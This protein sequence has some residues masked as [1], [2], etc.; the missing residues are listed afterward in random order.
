MGLGTGIL[1]LGFGIIFNSPSFMFITIFLFTLFFLYYKLIEEK[2][3]AARFGEE[4]LE[5]KRRTPFLIPTF[6]RKKSY[7]RIYR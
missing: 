6:R 3:L 7:K 5:Y 1:Y 2:E 4:Y